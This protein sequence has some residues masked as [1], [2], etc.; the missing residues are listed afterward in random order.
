MAIAPRH[1]AIPVIKASR[2]AAKREEP[3][4]SPVTRRFAKVHEDVVAGRT[5]PRA[6]KEV[7]I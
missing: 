5:S 4:Q 2:E 3:Y 1:I 6:E 7:A